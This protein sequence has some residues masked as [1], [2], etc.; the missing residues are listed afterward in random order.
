MSKPHPSAEATY[1]VLPH[2][3]TAFA[4][5]VTIPETLPTL[6]TSFATAADAELW[7][8]RHKRKAQEPVMS[9]H[10]RAVNRGRS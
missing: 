3:G 8:E 4:V 5:E 2:A 6:V 10:R 9:R 1:R 7:I